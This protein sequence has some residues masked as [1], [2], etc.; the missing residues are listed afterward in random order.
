MAYAEGDMSHVSED[1]IPE[2]LARLKRESVPCRQGCNF[3]FK[4][5]SLTR[6]A[7][8]Q[9]KTSMKL[10]MSNFIQDTNCSQVSMCVVMET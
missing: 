6:T 9:R 7:I 5:I 3:P 1:I 8:F 4:C 2:S 10:K